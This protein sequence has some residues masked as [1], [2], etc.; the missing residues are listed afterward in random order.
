MKDKS[1]HVSSISYNEVVGKFDITKNMCSHYIEC[2]R[3]LTF[4]L[5]TFYPPLDAAVDPIIIKNTI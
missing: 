2:H 5:R 1:P 4:Y 3:A